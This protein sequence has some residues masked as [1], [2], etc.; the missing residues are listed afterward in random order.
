MAP[1]EM[2]RSANDLDYLHA[3]ERFDPGFLDYLSRRADC[4]DNAPMES[5]LPP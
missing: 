1:R 3:L 4:W 2:F 5:F